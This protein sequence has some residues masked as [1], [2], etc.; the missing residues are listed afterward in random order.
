MASDEEDFQV[1]GLF[2]REAQISLAQTVF[3]PKVHPQ[4]DP[5][6]VSAADSKR[7]LGRYLAAIAP[8]RS[9]VELRQLVKAIYDAAVKLQHRRTAN[10][11]DARMCA[12][13][14]LALIELVEELEFARASNEKGNEWR[15]N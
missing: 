6:E 7:M 4:L 9:R 5:V 2:C 13:A 11:T 12:I 15:R 8:G 3:D 14:T 10:R 1:I